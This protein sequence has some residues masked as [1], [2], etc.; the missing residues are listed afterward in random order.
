MIFAL[1]IVDNVKFNL[2]I[3]AWFDVSFVAFGQFILLVLLKLL[4]SERKRFQISFKKFTFF[5]IVAFLVCQEYP[6]I[7]ANR[8]LA[9]LMLACRQNTLQVMLAVLVE[10]YEI[11]EHQEAP[12]TCHVWTSAC[13]NAWSRPL[14]H[15]HAF[16]IPNCN[17]YCC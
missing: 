7:Y 4:S 5:Y 16:S 9:C 14:Y 10:R 11:F 15:E 1:L 13:C 6:I 3:H 12:T 17:C 2:H 8:R